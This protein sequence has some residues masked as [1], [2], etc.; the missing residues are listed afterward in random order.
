[1]AA[2]SGRDFRKIDS[3]QMMLRKKGA[4]LICTGPEPYYCTAQAFYPTL[5]CLINEEFVVL[6]EH[7]RVSDEAR[8]L[9]FV[10]AFA[11]ALETFSRQ[12]LSSVK[13]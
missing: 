8:T 13:R 2:I 6:L 1:M 10:F 3:W 4:R 12:Y 9:R 7:G 11:F 5:D